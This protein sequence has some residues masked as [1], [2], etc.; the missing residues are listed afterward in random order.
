M[1]L[2]GVGPIKLVTLVANHQS[3]ISGA[4]RGAPIKLPKLVR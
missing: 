4:H 2:A 1:S 3:G